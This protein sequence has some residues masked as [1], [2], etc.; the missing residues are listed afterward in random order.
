[1]IEIAIRSVIDQNYPNLEHIIIDGGS[2]DGTLVAI[3]SFPHLRVISEEDKGMYDAL[4]KG[5]CLATG[6]IIG[7]LN[8]DDYYA[9][10]A[11]QK[12][13]NIF[14]GDPQ[15]DVVWGSADI[16]NNI[17]GGLIN[18]RLLYSPLGEKD[19]IPYLL[20]SIPV[21][22]ACFF[23]KHVFEKY[24]HFMDKLKI[25]GDREFMLRLALG[26]AKFHTSDSIV[27][28]YIAHDDSLTYSSVQ[29][30][31]ELWNHEHCQIAEFY[32]DQKSTQG[33]SKETYRQLH[34][35]SNLS[36]IKIALKKKELIK[37][38]RLVK[39]GWQKNPRWPIL[40]LDR[41]MKILR[42]LPKGE[43]FIV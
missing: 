40:F 15:A 1:M 22:N 16:R 7:F 5:V 38:L 14:K 9:K 29:K 10:D 6:E 33:F 2:T 32:L 31:F 18:K 3:K 13:I 30:N 26:E 17:A 34:T 36:L 24:G 8:S 39:N 19:Y 21:F 28:H 12:A 42:I 35:I 23:R 11:F 43:K 4:N 37:A 25:A 41:L 20:S 27:Y